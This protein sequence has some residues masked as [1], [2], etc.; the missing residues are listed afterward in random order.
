MERERIFGYFIKVGKLP[1][2]RLVQ[3]ASNIFPLKPSSKAILM[4]LMNTRPGQGQARFPWGLTATNSRGGFLDA[5]HE[6]TRFHRRSR[7]VSRVK[8]RRHE[9]RA[10]IRAEQGGLRRASARSSVRKEKWP[11]SPSWRSGS[12]HLRSRPHSGRTG[13]SLQCSRGQRLRRRPVGR[14]SI[15]GCSGAYGLLHGEPRGEL[16][17]DDLRTPRPRVGRAAA[18]NSGRGRVTQE[19]ARARAR[20]KPRRRGRPRVDFR[21]LYQAEGKGGS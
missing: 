19:A 10:R 7:T 15:R 11:H 5:G 9:G 12:G 8:E 6:K 4:N 18:E 14:E 13:R 1:Q 17:P 21:L 20:Q 16:G 2:Q 3:L